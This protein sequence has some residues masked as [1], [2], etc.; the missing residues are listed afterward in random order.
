MEA[1]SLYSAQKLPDSLGVPGVKNEPA[2]AE[3][4]S[5]TLGQGRS[6]MPR[7]NEAGEPQGLKPAL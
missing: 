5:S 1:R 4:V 3:D 6:H 7:S 2:N